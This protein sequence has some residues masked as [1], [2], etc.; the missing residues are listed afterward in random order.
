MLK[1]VD[2]QSFKHRLKW[3]N[4]APDWDCKAYFLY[5]KNISVDGPHSQAA[6][7]ILLI[8]KCLVWGYL[9]DISM[10]WPHKR[11][12]YSITSR[13]WRSY[14]QQTISLWWRPSVRLWHDHWTKWHYHRTLAWP[15]EFGVLHIYVHSTDQTQ[16]YTRANPN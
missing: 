8:L 11:N 12:W 7:F 13:L 15:S 14:H 10:T 2:L 9:Y 4:V 6:A 5:I 1:A 3:T 16:N